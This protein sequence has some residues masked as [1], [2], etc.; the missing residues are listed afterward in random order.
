MVG[1][2][3]DEVAADGAAEYAADGRVLGAVLRAVSLG[4]GVGV[5]VPTALADAGAVVFVDVTLGTGVGT[6]DTPVAWGIADGA[7]EPASAFR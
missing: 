1:G 4:G 7:P 3:A 5:D 6:G 2:R